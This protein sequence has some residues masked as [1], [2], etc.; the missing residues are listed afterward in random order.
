MAAMQEAP[1]PQ[2]A[3]SAP[4]FEQRQ[5]STNI[6]VCVQ[7]IITDVTHSPR[8]AQKRI[9]VK[10]FTIVTP[11]VRTDSLLRA[12]KQLR[13]NFGNSSSESSL[14][15]SGNASAAAYN[16]QSNDET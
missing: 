4:V 10:E 9:R 3:C 2:G 15:M 1:M 14:S 16:R 12:I 8:I 7:Q 11:V 6:F 13:L 5:A